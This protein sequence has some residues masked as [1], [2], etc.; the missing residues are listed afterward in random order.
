MVL[1][2]SRWKCESCGTLHM[3]RGDALR[4][5]RECKRLVEDRYRTEDYYSARRERWKTDEDYYK[6]MIR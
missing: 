2:V 1:R 5:E 3:A 4:C 6:N